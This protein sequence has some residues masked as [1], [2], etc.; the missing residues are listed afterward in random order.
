MYGRLS[1]CLKSECGAAEAILQLD[2]GLHVFSFIER[3]PGLLATRFFLTEKSTHLILLTFHA[4][5]ELRIVL[6]DIGL[7][8]DWHGVFLQRLL[9]WRPAET[10]NVRK[11]KD[12]AALVVFHPLFARVIPNK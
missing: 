10:Y 3:I 7:K 6:V 9:R 11:P 8:R 5:Y 2:D 12:V 1:F 4:D